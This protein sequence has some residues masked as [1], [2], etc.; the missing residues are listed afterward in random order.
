M[1]V[2]YRGDDFLYLVEVE[3]RNGGSTRRF[4]NQTDGSSSIEADDIELNTKDKSGSDYGNVTE[5]VSI[6]GVLTKGDPAIPFIKKA[7]RNKRMVRIIEVNTRELDAE[8]GLYKINSFE[9]TNSN[10]E[11]ATYSIEAALNG[12][13]KETTLQEL[14]EGAPDENEDDDDGKGGEGNTGGSDGGSGGADGDN[15]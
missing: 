14:P 13:I 2:E 10:G 6:E 3:D 8:E 7:I 12:K 15:K 4:F 1:A 11:F 5:T 9:Q